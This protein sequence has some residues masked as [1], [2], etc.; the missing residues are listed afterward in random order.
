M[1][2]DQFFWIGG[3]HK[4]GCI[5]IK[6][7]WFEPFCKLRGLPVFWLY[8]GVEKWNIALKGVKNSPPELNKTENL[9]LWRSEVILGQNCAFNFQ[10]LPSMIYFVQ[11][12]VLSKAV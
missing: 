4:I 2:A 3:D 6:M 1:R 7:E 12:I 11:N 8:Q 10:T 9:N 5:Y